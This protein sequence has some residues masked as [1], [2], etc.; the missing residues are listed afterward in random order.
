MLKLQKTSFNNKLHTNCYLIRSERFGWCAWLANWLARV[1]GGVCVCVW[2]LAIICNHNHRQCPNPRGVHWLVHKDHHW[3]TIRSLE[4]QFSVVT[5]SIPGRLFVW[6]VLPGM[7][8]PQRNFPSRVNDYLSCVH[9][10]F[11]SDEAAPFLIPVR[12]A[13]GRWIA[14]R[15]DP[16]DCIFTRNAER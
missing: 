14:A 13:N 9:D 10:N 12:N 15:R 7:D 11:S 6:F 8:V 16:S 4:E 2:V 5:F 1:G 3:I